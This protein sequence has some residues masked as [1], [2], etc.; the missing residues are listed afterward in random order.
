M[1][2]GHWIAGGAT[3]VVLLLVVSATTFTQAAVVAGTAHATAGPAPHVYLLRGLLNVFSLG[4]DRL[5]EKIERYGIGTTVSSHWP[6]R[7]LAD[8]AIANCKSGRQGAVMLI[9]H[10]AGATSVI[11]MAERLNQAGV[12]VALVV[13]LDPM[14]PP[15]VPS[16][17]RKL[18]NFYFS[19]G[20]GTS[21]NPGPAFHGSLANVDLKNRSDLGHISVGQADDIHAQVLKYV[22]AARNASCHR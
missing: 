18:V 9:G 5:G 6:W 22:L 13:T 14:F 19:D 17:V 2:T 1:K 3:A 21:V 10:S 15:K 11:D 7:T 16:N 12:N 4:M 8:E 20:V